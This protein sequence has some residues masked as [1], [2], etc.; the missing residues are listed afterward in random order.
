MVIVIG[1][2]SV[3]TNMNPSVEMFSLTPHQSRPDLRFDGEASALIQAPLQGRTDQTVEG[4]VPWLTIQ[5]VL[6]SGMPLNRDDR[7]NP[8]LARI[9]FF[10]ARSAMGPGRQW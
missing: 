8:E 3:P 7:S 2:I 10:S 1:T 4:V 9:Q 6:Q 5:I